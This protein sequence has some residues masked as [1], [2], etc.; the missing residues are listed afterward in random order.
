MQATSGCVH[1]G[2]VPV[3][4]LARNPHAITEGHQTNPPSASHSNIE[5]DKKHCMGTGSSPYIN[6][7][8]L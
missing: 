4:R 8:V 7:T 6:L 3:S 2:K 5:K 1:Q